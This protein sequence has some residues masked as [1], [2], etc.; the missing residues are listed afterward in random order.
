V[1][2]IQAANRRRMREA[3]ESAGF[4]TWCRMGGMMASVT[5]H[6]ERNRLGESSDPGWTVDP[7]CGDDTHS[8][9]RCRRR[10]DA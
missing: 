7:R 5:V 6:G 9:A 8:G 3:Q 4:Q 10:G 1:G 2:A